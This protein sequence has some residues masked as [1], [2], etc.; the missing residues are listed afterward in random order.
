VKADKVV[1]IDG[2][3]DSPF[4]LG[5]PPFMASEVRYVAGACWDRDDKTRVIYVTVD[6]LNAGRKSSLME[7]ADLILVYAGEPR[8]SPVIRPSPDVHRVAGI[9][10]IVDYIAYLDCP[11][12]LAGPH[13]TVNDGKIDDR[14]GFQRVV[15]GDLSKFAHETLSE[16]SEIDDVDPSVERTN[17]DLKKFSILGAGLA[18][19]NRGYPSFLSIGVELYRGCPSAMEGGCSFCHH[20]LRTTV[21]YR[22]VEDV[23]AEV[24]KI[25]EL[26][27]ENILFQCPCFLSY[28][29]SPNDDEGLQLDRDAIEKLLEGVRSVA[30]GLKGIHVE[31]INP[32]VFAI[33]WQESK[34]ILKTVLSQCTD[35]NFTNVKAFSFDDQVQ[36]MNN[37][38]S[39]TEQTVEVVRN[40]AEAGS[41]IG[42]DGL[43]R[44]LPVIELVYGLAGETQETLDVN[45]EAMRDLA[46][47]GLVRGVVARELVPVPGTTIA[48]RDDLEEQEGL[49]NHL[50]S[51]ENEI[52]RPL[53]G[54][55]APPGQLVRDVYTYRTVEDSTAAIKVGVN[56]PGFLIYG[57]PKLNALQ[58]VRVTGANE[59]NLEALTQP[60]IPKTVS[61]DVLRLIPEMSEERIDDFMRVRPENEL[62]FYQLFEQPSVGR[63]AA[64]YFEFE[65][66]T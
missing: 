7:G 66:A 32:G 23:V 42:P 59:G 10:D 65:Q 2:F 17:E 54:K 37:I 56:A 58:D 61:R 14:L 44:L 60:L 1:I 49:Q 24:A 33:D 13:V 48:K 47:E 25:S 11:K 36:L 34:R 6:D 40:L 38:S 16:G 35:G 4:D 3:T 26:G 19:Q 63:R 45:L 18:I 20:A 29:S 57:S 8:A 31:G 53:N 41:E 28:F 27:C 62:D 51:L 39:T 15:T 30:P 9:Q 12:V 22:P 52:N 46:S 55:L 50:E 43:P 64:S 21:E 5:V